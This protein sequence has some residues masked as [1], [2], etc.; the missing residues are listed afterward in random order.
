MVLGM[1]TPMHAHGCSNSLAGA[2]QGCRTC[3]DARAGNAPGRRPG[4]ALW[5]HEGDEVVV[6]GQ[7]CVHRLR[8]GK[9]D[10]HASSAR[11]HWR[12][13][14]AGCVQRQAEAC[15]HLRHPDADLRWAH[16][17]QEQAARLRGGQQQQQSVSQCLD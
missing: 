13:G 12:R 14:Q 15:Q 8:A 3:R 2:Q 1:T 6:G 4:S 16:R 10:V 9:G 11:C 17:V 7:E 5:G